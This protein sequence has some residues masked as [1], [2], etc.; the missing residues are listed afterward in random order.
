MEKRTFNFS[1]GLGIFV[2][3]AAGIGTAILG[4]V[5]RTDWIQVAFYSIA[6]TALVL[7][8][9]HHFSIKWSYSLFSKEKGIEDAPIEIT[10]EN[11]KRSLFW[12][13]ISKNWI[14]VTGFLILLGLFVI[15]SFLVPGF[16]S[17]RTVVSALIF[18]GFLILAFIAYKFLNINK[19][20]IIGVSILIGLFIIGS[21]SLDGFLSIQNI[22]S[23]LVFASFL[24][25]A[26]IGQTLVVML[27]GLDL[28][29]PFLIGASNLGL[30]SMISLGVPPW[31]AFIVI[32]AF[33]LIVGLFNGLI[34]YNLQGQALIVTLGVGF[35]CV[36]GVQI[37]VSLPTVTGGTVF[38]V[39]PDW[40]KNLASL[41]GKFFGL[42]IPPVI[43]IWILVAIVLI[44]GLRH[45][46]WG[47]NL[48]ALGGKRL[49][50]DRLSISERV[51]WVGVY[52]ISGFTSAA[53][54]AMLL[55]WSG[56][57][58]IGVGDQ[59]LFLTVA[60]V[61]VGGTSLL[62]GYGGYGFTVIGCLALQVISTFLAGL[63]LS[64]E[65]QQFIFGLL[66][67]PLVALYSRSPHIR[68]QI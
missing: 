32:L 67:L 43:L 2:A 18:L 50:A 53:T 7:W 1:K 24:G 28:S 26:T 3:V 42:P 64:F 5:D 35:M 34:S 46:K 56:G 12:E 6:V 41:N 39:V 29:I 9:W 36:G 44:V 19:S 49:S 23:M 13:I 40:L 10:D 51:Y 37:L 68:E 59:Y 55:G 47:R 52:V 63:G 62:G 61:A 65:G 11:K 14:V 22:K 58:F 31:L 25:I 17:G 33:G 30:M 45:T 8:G 48:I 66:I 20:V 27:G 54:G 38:G 16:F 60:A 57:G 15:L 4:Y 21:V